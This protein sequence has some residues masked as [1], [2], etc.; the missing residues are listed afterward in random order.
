MKKTVLLIALLTFSFYSSFSQS[1]KVIYNLTNDASETLKKIEDPNI[2]AMVAEQLSKPIKFELISSNGVSEFKQS[3]N[4]DIVDTEG[5][6]TV[7]MSRNQM[8]LYKNQI[9]R[10][11]VTQENYKSRFFLIKEDLEDFNWK[12]TSEKIKI[13]NYICTK[14]TLDIG[15]K[16]IVAWFTPEIPISDGPFKYYGLPG[17]IMK[18]INDKSICEVSKITPSKEIL[19]IPEPTK[20]KKVSREKFDKIKAQ[21]EKNEEKPEGGFKLIVKEY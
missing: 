19:N 1:I 8:I 5:N 10:K 11:L 9:K 15:N 7:I 13:G 12:I 16:T 18:L 14:A 3:Y 4:D 6:H 21:K 17:L 2:R 20:G